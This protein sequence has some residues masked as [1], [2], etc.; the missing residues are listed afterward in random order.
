MKL[1]GLVVGVFCLALMGADDK[2]DDAAIKAAKAKLIGTWAAQSDECEEHKAPA[3]GLKKTKL[4]ITED[5]ATL[6]E[7]VMQKIASYAIDPTKKPAHLD[8]TPL[9]GPAKGKHVKAIYSLEGDTLKL[10]ITLDGPDRPT[11]FVARKG[12]P[13][14]V[15]VFKKA[16]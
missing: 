16:Q 4:V 11:D 1:R 5:R 2:K 15:M 3:E 10:A 7:D 13:V 9:E 6:H 14:R 8:L 12:L